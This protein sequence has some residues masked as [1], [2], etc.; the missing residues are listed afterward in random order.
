MKGT[1]SL[2][3][4]AVLLLSSPCIQEQSNNA[5]EPFVNCEAQKG[6]LR[7][8][9]YGYA[10][11]NHIWPPAFPVSF[12][13]TIAVQLTPQMKVFL[14]TNGDRFELWMGTAQVPGNNVW[15]FLGDLADSCRLP[16]DPADAVKLLNIR[17]EV[18]ELQQKQFEQ[19]HKDFMAALRGYV[20]MV[21]GRSAFFMAHKLK[22]GGVD[23]GIYPIVHDNS[24]E[25]F[26]IDEWNLPVDGQITPMVKWVRELQRF[27]GASLH[28]SLD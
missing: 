4:L 10:V 28:R 27:A 12:G 8:G 11:M 23:S 15:D 13:I 3:V 1:Y 14:H 22:G 25:H 24:W 2:L 6:A 20:S 26:E 21:Q 19:L 5:P 17:W 9:A 18:K 16:P 7:S